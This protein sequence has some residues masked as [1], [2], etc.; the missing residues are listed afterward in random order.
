MR[1]YSR[2]AVILYGVIVLLVGTGL[3]IF[4]ANT[5]SITTPFTGLIP[6]TK[7]QTPACFK[8]VGNE[9]EDAY[10]DSKANLHFYYE[11]DGKLID[12]GWYTSSNHKEC[13]PCNYRSN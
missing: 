10:C 5:L 2:R 6:V 7:V 9:V 4:L 8:Y 12:S 11:G 3:G 1:G 13:K